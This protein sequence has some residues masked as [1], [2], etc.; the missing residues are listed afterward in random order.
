M[1]SQDFYKAMLEKRAMEDSWSQGKDSQEVANSEVFSN[2]ADQR[3]QLG[4]LLS[5]ASSAQRSDTAEVGKLLP[6][7]KKSSDT[8]SSNP[9]LKVAMHAAFFDGMRSSYL[10]KTAGPEYIHTAYSA[11]EDE[12]DKISSVGLGRMSR[13]AIE[14]A[15]KQVKRRNPVAVAISKAPASA[16]R[17]GGGGGAGVWKIPGDMSKGA[18]VFGAIARAARKA[19][20]VSGGAA[21][22]AAKAPAAA[23]K[24]AAWGP[25]TVLKGSMKSKPSTVNWGDFK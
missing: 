5:S 18:G 4:D 16:K 25:G 8:M 24:P 3:S 2:K 7:A 21:A 19:R 12:L 17:V 15:L 23:A 6:K 9:M 10:M 22:S 14:T 13:E 1:M 11:F 20:R